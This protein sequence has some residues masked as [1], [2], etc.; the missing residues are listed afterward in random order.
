MFAP[1]TSLWRCLQVNAHVR[2]EPTVVF[3]LGTA[4]THNFLIT[5]ILTIWCEGNTLMGPCL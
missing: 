5:F 2:E 4:R 3:I 1:I